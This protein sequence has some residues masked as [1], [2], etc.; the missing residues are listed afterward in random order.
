MSLVVSTAL[1]VRRASCWIGCAYFEHML[2]DFAVRLRMMQM[3]VVKIVGV[4]VV[5]D[6]GMA[7][8][9]AVLMVVILMRC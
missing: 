5:F 2:D 9:I 1:V 6:G 4:P 7:A 3:P 8:V